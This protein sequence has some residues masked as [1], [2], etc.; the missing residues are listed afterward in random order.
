[1]S[2]SLVGSEMCIRDRDD[3][4]RPSTETGER[5]NPRKRPPGRGATRGRGGAEGALPRDEGSPPRRGPL[6]PTRGAGGRGIC[7]TSQGIRR[8]REHGGKKLSHAP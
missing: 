3:T 8:R 6:R 7:E 5:P 4:P 2:A 1:M